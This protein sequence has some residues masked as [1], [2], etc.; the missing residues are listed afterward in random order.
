MEFKLNPCELHSACKEIVASVDHRL[1]PEVKSGLT[2]PRDSFILMTDPLR[3]R[4]LLL[5]LLINAAKFTQEGRVDLSV[6]IDEEKQQVRF[7]VTD[8]GC[9]IPLELQEKIFER[10]EK[11]HEYIQGTGLGLAICKMIAANLGGSLFVDPNYTGGARFVF[12]HPFEPP[13]QNKE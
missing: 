6:E 11:V 9:G 1:Q 3:L 8:T 2:F 5:N 4:Q 13:H 10:F 7:S 12:I